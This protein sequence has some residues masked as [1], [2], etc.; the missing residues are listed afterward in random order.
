MEELDQCV[1][2]TIGSDSGGLIDPDH[3]GFNDREYLK[4][5]EEIAAAAN[6]YIT[7]NFKINE[8]FQNK[9]A[10]SKFAIENAKFA[11]ENEKFTIENGKFVIVNAKFAI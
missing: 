3:P 8:L 10:V 9:R 1:V 2:D 4:R 7:Q 6:S 5:R 11:I